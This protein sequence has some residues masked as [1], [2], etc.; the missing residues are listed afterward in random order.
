MRFQPSLEQLFS[1][2]VDGKTDY[3]GNNLTSEKRRL[4]K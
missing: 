4:K 3:K 1:E 2:L